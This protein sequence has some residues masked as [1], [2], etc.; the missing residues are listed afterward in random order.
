MPA[1]VNTGIGNTNGTAASFVTMGLA[2]GFVA[3]NC[4]VATIALQDVTKSVTG[5]H[6]DSV[7]GPMSFTRI[8]TALSLTGVKIEL[9]ATGPTGTK[10]SPSFINFILN[11]VSHA[12]AV[13]AWY[14]G[15]NSI[16][17]NGNTNNTNANPSIA[18]ATQDN[19]NF[20][21]AG[22]GS[23]GATLPTALTGNMRRTRNSLG[24]SE[25]TITIND[26]TAAA[27]GSVTNAVTL[28]A[29]TWGAIA[30]ELRSAGGGGGGGGAIGAIASTLARMRRG[31]G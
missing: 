4:C 2:G 11:G 15:V 30:V 26:N 10:A 9:W 31:G 6:D 18:L 12:G 28:A 1:F 20:V 7:G 8:G 14:S 13:C 3:G 17:I 22:F 19:D 21:V 16:G 27:P 25:V 5:T 24:P 23:V 29:T